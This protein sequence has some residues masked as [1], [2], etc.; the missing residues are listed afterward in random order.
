MPKTELLK[1]SE[2][3]LFLRSNFFMFR[4][5]LR[6]LCYIPLSFIKIKRS[7]RPNLPVKLREDVNRRRIVSASCTDDLQ[8]NRRR[9]VRS[10]SFAQVIFSFLSSQH[11]LLFLFDVFHLPGPHAGCAS[12]HITKKLERGERIPV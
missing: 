8:V 1:V 4:C 6:K 7:K 11:L 5:L 9:S 10:S 3:F 2:L 12:R